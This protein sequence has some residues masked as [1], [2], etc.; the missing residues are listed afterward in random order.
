M[1]ICVHEPLN[2]EYK[3]CHFCEIISKIITLTYK[4]AFY[5]N[6]LAFIFLRYYHS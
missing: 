3:S 1:I 6:F 4:F 2:L 5:F